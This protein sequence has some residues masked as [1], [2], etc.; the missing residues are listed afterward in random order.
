MLQQTV[1]CI[2]FII[3][4]DLSNV[5]KISSIFCIIFK[6]DLFFYLM[7]LINAI[8]VINVI[9]M[10]DIF[11]RLFSIAL[12]HLIIVFFLYKR[13]LFWNNVCFCVLTLQVC[14]VWLVRIVPPQ[15]RRIRVMLRMFFY[16]LIRW[17][18]SFN[19]F[20]RI[21]V[22]IMY[23]HILSCQSFSNSRDYLLWISIFF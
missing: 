11:L 18:S 3:P 6:L 1:L 8:D 7:R 16:K 5:E 9:E 21:G 23:F 22:H 19:W 15:F 4:I 17:E 14:I 12:L 13:L 2:I 10:D 20:L